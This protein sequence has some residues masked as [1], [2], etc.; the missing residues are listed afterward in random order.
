MRWAPVFTG[1]GPDVS[2]ER[3]VTL[4]KEGQV[5][6][7]LGEHEQLLGREQHDARRN[8]TFDATEG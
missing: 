8:F 3:S 7:V 6:N 1:T 2:P 5:R 4:C